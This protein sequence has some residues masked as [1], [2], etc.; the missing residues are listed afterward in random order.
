MCLY[1][2][3]VRGEQSTPNLQPLV[4]KARL[5]SWRRQGLGRNWYLGSLSPLISLSIFP[6]HSQAAVEEEG[7]VLEAIFCTHKHW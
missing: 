6:L 7:V 3:G 1:Y 5:E 4:P 2:F